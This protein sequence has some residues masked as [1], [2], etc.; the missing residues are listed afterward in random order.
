MNN[1]LIFLAI[2]LLLLAAVPNVYTGGL[3]LI[4]LR[5]ERKKKGTAT[6]TVGSKVLHIHMMK[7]GLKNVRIIKIGIT[8]CGMMHVLNQVKQ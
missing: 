6:V 8:I 5:T 2:P 7:I 3:G 4:L 1:K